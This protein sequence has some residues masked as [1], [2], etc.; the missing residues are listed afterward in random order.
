MRTIV[1]IRD[2]DGWLFRSMEDGSCFRVRGN[3]AKVDARKTVEPELDRA[4]GRRGWV[5][6]N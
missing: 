5:Y 1:A 2:T 6:F 3:V 4:Y